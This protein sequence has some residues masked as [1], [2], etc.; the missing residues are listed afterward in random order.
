MDCTIKLYI[1]SLFCVVWKE[2]EPKQ[3]GKRRKSY[4]KWGKDDIPNSHNWFMCSHFDSVVLLLQWT[5]M[6]QDDGEDSLL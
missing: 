2:K 1:G 6:G 4:G 3:K 5:K